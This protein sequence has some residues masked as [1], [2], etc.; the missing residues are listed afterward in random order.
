MV[1][2]EKRVQEEEALKLKE[3]NGVQQRDNKIRLIED[4]L[5]ALQNENELLR[6]KMKEAAES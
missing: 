1:A 5:K 6:F 3:K 4:K 2:V